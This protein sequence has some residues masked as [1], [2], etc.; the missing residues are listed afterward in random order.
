LLGWLLWGLRPEPGAGRG[1]TLELTLTSIDL[2]AWT[3]ILLLDG[4]LTRAAPKKLRYRLPHVADRI[5]HGGRRIR[6]ASP[7][8]GPGALRR[9]VTLPNHVNSHVRNPNQ[10]DLEQQLPLLK[11]RG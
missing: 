2:L 8:P 1:L 6:L 3:R 5:A 11:E 7:P 4:D 9:V 10:Q